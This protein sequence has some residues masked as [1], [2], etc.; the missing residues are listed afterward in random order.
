MI[1]LLL[2]AGPILAYTSDLQFKTCTCRIVLF[3]RGLCSATWECVT[4]SG[5][6]W[7]LVV[8]RKKHLLFFNNT[9][10]VYTTAPAFSCDLHR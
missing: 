10:Q 4:Y 8:L 5:A 1:R 9:F 2:F 7:Q 6:S 3:K